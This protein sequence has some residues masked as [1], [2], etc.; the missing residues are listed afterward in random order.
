MQEIFKQI[1]ELG[2]TKFGNEYL[3]LGGQQNTTAPRSAPTG[4][5]ATLDYTPAPTRRVRRAISIG[6]GQ[7]VCA[8]ATTASRS[9]STPACST[10][11]KALSQ[12]LD[13]TSTT[14]G[15]AGISAALSSI[16]GAY[17]AVQQVV[18][19]TGAQANRL[20]SVRP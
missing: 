8:D 15:L 17:N 3:F 6:D 13:P 18:G 12:A 14:Y 16:D 10:P 7:T 5:G 1:A 19:D 20:S 2:N 11:W 9:S 4:S